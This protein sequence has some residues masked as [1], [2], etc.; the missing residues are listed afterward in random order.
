MA[1]TV[2]VDIDGTISIVGDR[3]KFLK[4]KDWES[5]YMAAMEDKPNW[6]VIYTVKALKNAGCTILF[7]TGRRESSRSLT[8]K[9][10]NKYLGWMPKGHELLMRPDG[11]YRHDTILKPELVRGFLDE[12][13]LIFEDRNSM[14][15][16][17]RELGMTVFHVADGDF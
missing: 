15:K 8:L 17:W 3:L 11:D 16:K 2:V 5:F 12:I 14:V 10:M 13:Y 9:W 4:D 7:V 1:G 6:P